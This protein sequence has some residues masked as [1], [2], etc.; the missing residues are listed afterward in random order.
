[1]KSAPTT[2]R[3]PDPLHG[4]TLHHRSQQQQRG[5]MAATPPPM[6]PYGYADQAVPGS[7]TSGSFRDPAPPPPTLQATTSKILLPCR[8][9]LY[10]LIGL[11]LLLWIAVVLVGTL[12]AEPIPDGLTRREF[13]HPLTWFDVHVFRVW[14][15][16]LPLAPYLVR[17][18]A[19]GLRIPSSATGAGPFG[20]HLRL[21]P[22]VTLPLPS[23]AAYLLVIAVRIA[24]YVG[25]VA[26]QR[27]GPQ[28]LVLV[29]DHLLLAA[30]MV[31]C[32]QS[33]LVM[34]LSDVYKAEVLRGVDRSAGARQLAVVVALVVSMFTM[35]F[36]YSDM[37]C[38]ARW[39]HHPTESL[40]ALAVG[41]L[42]FQAPVVVW[43]ISRCGPWQ[44]APIYHALSMSARP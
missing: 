39:Y 1:M 4:G 8:E 10:A 30:S 40:S 7:P 15:P 36:V 32:F 31:A 29:S 9:V 18:A 11:P 37:Y 25:H 23:L 13:E 19:M 28:G 33:E 21:R 27:S 17:V 5:G 43:I 44:S 20:G 6:P 2:H 26:L 41:A 35:V 38:T 24:L 34:C 12:H 14:G 3:H 22:G 16:L 42:V